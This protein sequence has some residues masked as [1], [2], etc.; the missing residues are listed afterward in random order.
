MSGAQQAE[1]RHRGA[2]D[3]EVR[4]KPVLALALIQNHLQ[5]SQSHAQQA[6]PNEVDPGIPR[7]DSLRTRNGGSKIRKK[8]RIRE[9][10]PT[11]MLMRKIHRQL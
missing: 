10:T 8:V 3:D 6:Q 9:S 4:F 2:A 5:E 11:G 7:V 1:Q